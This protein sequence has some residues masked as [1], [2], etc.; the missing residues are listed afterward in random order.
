MESGPK[1]LRGLTGNTIRAAFELIAHAG[2]QVQIPP[3]RSDYIGRS[4]SLWYC[5]DTAAG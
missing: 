3:T 1:M 2:I 4:H 5:D